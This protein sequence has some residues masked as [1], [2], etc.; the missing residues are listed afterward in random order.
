MLKCAAIILALLGA[1]LPHSAFAILL[2]SGPPAN[3]PSG[4]SLKAIDGESLL[5]G[6]T[7]SAPPTTCTNT[8][9]Y[10]ASN[11]FA[12]AASAAYNG[13]SWDDPRFFAITNFFAFYPTNST[14]TFKTLGMNTTVH[15]AT[16]TSISATLNGAGIWAI[17]GIPGAPDNNS[18]WGNE[19]VGWNVDEPANFA[20]LTTSIQAEGALATNRFQSV[21]QTWNQLNYQNLCVQASPCPPFYTLPQVYGT[22]ITIPSDGTT[23]ANIPGMDIY[24]FAMSSSSSGLTECGTIYSIGGGSCSTDQ[25]NRGD[26]YGDMVDDMRG[27]LV[28]PAVTAPIFGPYIENQDGLWTSGREILTQEF[29]WA[30]WSTLLHGARSVDYFGTTTSGID[31]DPGSQGTFGFSN[32]VLAGSVIPQFNPTS[33]TATMINQVTITDTM[34]TALAPVLNS[35]FA[36]S[37]A[38]VSPV[39]YVFPTYIGHGSTALVNGIDLSTHWYNGGSYSNSIGT[40]NNG[41]YI[42]STLRGSETQSTVSGTITTH[43]PNCNGKTVTVVNESRTLTES[44]S[45]GMCTFVD[46]FGYPNNLVHIYEIAYP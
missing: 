15:F 11:G 28:S 36:L 44:G 8:H 22:S 26:H 31:P 29:N 13:V 6:C 34:V 18:G 30:V 35:P 43:D 38:S 21:G 46:T 40:F 23:T 14:T 24:W 45:A 12:Y 41:F 7:G 17:P 25:I 20:S 5:G 33:L 37:Y 32:V 1:L 10:Y 27:W 16:G 39:G 3:L 9:S 19:T 4:V 42:L 2:S